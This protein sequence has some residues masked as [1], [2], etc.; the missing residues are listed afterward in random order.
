MVD[1]PV[2]GLRVCGCC[3]ITVKNAS[4]VVSPGVRNRLIIYANQYTDKPASNPCHQT[5][6]E[7]N[8]PYAAANDTTGRPAAVKSSARRYRVLG[9]HCQ[10][11][12]LFTSLFFK[13][14]EIGYKD[15]TYFPYDNEFH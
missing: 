14:V 1:N 4:S 2:L 6:S 13:K 9:C 11:H 15:T 10:H 8:N 5:I 12:L 3:V 7:K